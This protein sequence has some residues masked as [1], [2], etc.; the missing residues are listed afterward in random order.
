MFYLYSYVDEVEFFLGFNQRKKNLNFSM[1]RSDDVPTEVGR[2]RIRCWIIRTFKCS[3]LA[4][5]ILNR[6]CYLLKDAN[7]KPIKPKCF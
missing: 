1:R 5:K 4:D 6:G 7:K 3:G 2:I